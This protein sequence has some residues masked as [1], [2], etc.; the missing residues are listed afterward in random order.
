MILFSSY[1]DYCLGFKDKRKK[2]YAQLMY[3]SRCWLNSISEKLSRGK[4]YF[5][6]DE[7]SFGTFDFGKDA[8]S[9]II[10]SAEDAAAF[11]ARNLRT[12]IVREN[13]LVPIYQV[14]EINSAGMNWIS[15][16][17]GR[18]I[19]EK[20]SGRTTVMGVSKRV[21]IDTGENRL[22][23]E[24]LRRVCEL[25]DIK[26]SCLPQELYSG[27]EAEFSRI[28][29]RFLNSEAREITRWENLPPNNTL[30][31]DRYYRQIWNAWTRLRSL[32]ELIADDSEDF[33]RVLTT[34]V[35]W[36]I[37]ST[38]SEFYSF[39]QTPVMFDYDCFTVKPVTDSLFGISPDKEQIA[40]SFTDNSI[41]VSVNNEN[42]DVDIS[43]NNITV[44][45]DEEI[46][47]S[48]TITAADF[49]T[50]MRELIHLMGLCGT[51]AIRKVEPVNADCVITSP[52]SDTPYYSA[53]NSIPT[54]IDIRFAAQSFIFGE[55]SYTLSLAQSEV[56]C[57][58]N[59]ERFLSL[60]NYRNDSEAN[61]LFSF[62]KD[63]I[64]SKQLCFLFP[65]ALNEFE[66]TPI[67]R[68]ARM[69]FSI[70]ETLPQSIGAVI[71]CENTPW[72]S[73][74]YNDNTL[75]LVVDIVDTNLTITPIKGIAEKSLGSGRPPIIWER[76]PTV[77]YSIFDIAQ[78]EAERFFRLSDS[79]RST[80]LL[81]NGEWTTLD[82]S[83]KPIDIENCLN[84][85][86]ST[87]SGITEKKRIKVI[88]LTN[89]LEPLSEKYSA[90]NV[91]M[92]ECV[93][94]FQKV[95][96]HAQRYKKTL[97]RD[98]LPDL[99]IKQTLSKFNLV[100]D[101]TI[102]PLNNEE[103]KIE[104]SNRFTLPAGRDLYSF[105][106]VQENS[107]ENMKY[108]AVLEKSGVFPLKEP[109]ECR[110]TMKYK[111]GADNP[112]TLIFSPTDSQAAG[113]SSVTAQW[114]RDNADDSF[115]DSVYPE[116]PQPV[117]I[118]DLHS[119]PCKARHGAPADLFEWAQGSIFPKPN[120]CCH[121]TNYENWKLDK[122]GN[123]YFFAGIYIDGIY[124]DVQFYDNDRIIRN[125]ITPRGIDIFFNVF[126][127]KRDEHTFYRASN[128][129]IDKDSYIEDTLQN[130][131]Y[132]SSCKFTSITFPLSIILA[133]GRSVDATGFPQEFTQAVREN[134]G[135]V[136]EAYKQN[137]KVDEKHKSKL[138][139]VLCLLYEEMDD[140]FYET[141][142]NLVENSKK[143]YLNS[144][145][146]YAVG[147]CKTENQKGLFEQI[148]RLFTEQSGKG[149]N[150]LSRALWRNPDMIFNADT[151]TLFNCL[152]QAI[153]MVEWLAKACK[154][155][156]EAIMRCIK[157]NS[158]TSCLEIILAMFRLREVDDIEVKK[159][160]R[161]NS[162]LIDDLRESLY[163]IA[164]SHD[165][166]MFKY[167]RRHTYIRLEKSGKS[168]L[169]ELLYALMLYSAGNLD[170]DTIKISGIS[171]DE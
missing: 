145:I 105:E 5:G 112:Y 92:E 48:E 83:G 150:M 11:I 94:G 14:R 18:T 165:E 126:S 136:W 58:D 63:R 121:V 76:F 82:N 42:F 46:V 40:L 153:K 52:F 155:G 74:N 168:E 47:F 57:A 118:D 143:G 152:K 161:C 93:T 67:K 77:T 116:F 24:F 157:Y 128:I 124:T 88:S 78:D 160:L 164:D 4:G 154:K 102:E 99:S 15:R 16:R 61:M 43:D 109:V 2:E 98:H 72:F 144:N 115:C 167:I 113:F 89:R 26:H 13:T 156:H 91:T 29:T 96:Q 171:D 125:S 75:L 170:G 20:L 62:F 69:N 54:R 79:C 12:K 169:P 147:A 103:I 148:A 27:E 73:E 87:H 127:V 31:S 68:A 166:A 22:F 149:A 120:Y 159:Q 162:P 10:S 51:P 81:H 122:N 158:I 35:F 65:D 86:I 146:G 6:T 71:G 135:L 163:K 36:K 100:K 140:E 64:N 38:A 97:W 56:L 114:R 32:D 141:L 104:L 80:P 25:I 111:Y 129:C 37:F 108:C 66:L 131:K 107:A 50:E 134:I 33:D 8:L 95:L 138:L 151:K 106:L 55:D 133:G 30:L 142:I 3:L 9:V 39:P 41:R 110:L 7:F 53:D 49:E 45:Q 44:F 17:T 123:W 101:Q 117:G 119:Y 70:I 21:S 1:E 60:L 23:A 90:V 84:D 130:S 34:I 137:D 59:T 19:K 139:S 85:Y 132:L 28:Y